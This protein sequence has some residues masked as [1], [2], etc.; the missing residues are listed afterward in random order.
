MR[1][2]FLDL[3]TRVGWALF[4]GPL[5]LP[6]MGTYRLPKAEPDDYAGRTLPL[7]EWLS[8]MIINE[9]IKLVGF[10][11]PIVMAPSTGG[12][13][14]TTAQTIRLQISLA[15]EIET[16]AAEHQTPC[17]EV[18]SMSAKKALAG[19]AR[20]ANKKQDMIDAAHARGWNVED[21]HQADALGVAMVIYDMLG[22]PV[23][24]ML[25]A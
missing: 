19:K 3:S 14:F 17:Y 5:L 20:L 4:E 9:D 6:R 21:E 16:T 8:R 7:R 1:G 15:S 2:L 22:T 11:S 12:G 13:K 23:P 18:A 25:T 24:L 10:E